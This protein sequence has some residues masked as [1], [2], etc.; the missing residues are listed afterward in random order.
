MRLIL[1]GATPSITD[2][3]TSIAAIVGVPLSMIAFIK[4]VRRDKDKDR[5][6]QQ[7]SK[8]TQ[9]LTSQTSE[10]RY[11]SIQMFEHNKLVEAQ[12][13]LQKRAQEEH[14]AF[15]SEEL[16]ITR[17]KRRMEIRPYF[18]FRQGAPSGYNHYIQLLNKGG[19]ASHV[20]LNFNPES[21]ESIRKDNK[22]LT[23]DRASTFDFTVALKAINRYA[24]IPIELLF[25]DQDGNHYNQTITITGDVHEVS[26]ITLVE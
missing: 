16:E 7:L 4:L 9:E 10:F 25:E 2:W 12:L 13:D 19:E 14:R 20:S 5:Q 15:K 1:L 26:G 24:P 6:L 22:K 18:I 3:I 23:I 8:Q 21:I 17:Q 11:H